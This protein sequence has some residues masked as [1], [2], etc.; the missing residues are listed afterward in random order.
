MNRDIPLVSGS[1]GPEL[2]PRPGLELGPGP[3]TEPGLG[4]GPG[5][6]LCTEAYTLAKRGNEADSGCKYLYLISKYL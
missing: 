3:G 4:P 2:G 6:E 1:Q 5:P